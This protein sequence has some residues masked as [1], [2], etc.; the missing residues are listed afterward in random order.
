MHCTN[1][2]Q[3]KLVHTM[4]VHHCNAH[5][6]HYFRGLSFGF[7]LVHSEGHRVLEGAVQMH[8]VGLVPLQDG[9][10]ASI[11][12]DPH[13]ISFLLESSFYAS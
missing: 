4:Y 3:E 13:V 8:L 9:N 7:A 5:L 11:Q 6:H 10:I 1:F 2:V 12:S